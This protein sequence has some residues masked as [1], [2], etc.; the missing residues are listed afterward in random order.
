MASL[1]LVSSLLVVEAHEDGRVDHV[2]VVTM[3]E[4]R[5]E[6]S[7]NPYVIATL[8]VENCSLVDLRRENPARTFAE[9]GTAILELI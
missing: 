8:Y 5:K 2:S 3:S 1:L 6:I 9:F 4:L 7:S